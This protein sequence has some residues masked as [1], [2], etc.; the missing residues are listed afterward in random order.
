MHQVRNTLKCVSDKDK[1]AF[2]ADLI[3]Y[4]TPTE[5]AGYANIEDVRKMGGKIS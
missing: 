4:H 2:T 3:Y 1:K 5:K